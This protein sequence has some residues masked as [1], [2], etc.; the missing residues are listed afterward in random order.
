M[1]GF[2]LNIRNSWIYVYVEINKTSEI[3]IIDLLLNRCDNSD[4][5]LLYSNRLYHINPYIVGGGMLVGE[6][7]GGDGGNRTRVSNL[8]G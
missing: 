8:E 6:G 2:A 1:Q 5:G 7:E 4:T 3:G